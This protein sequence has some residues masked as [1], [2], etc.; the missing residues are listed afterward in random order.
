M[1]TRAASLC[2]PRGDLHDDASMPATEWTLKRNCSLSPAA[3][4][5]VYASL[6]VMSLGIATYFWLHGAT[7]VMPFAWV[8]LLVFGALLSVY[9]RHATDRERIVLVPDRLTV[10][11]LCGGRVERTEFVPQWVQVADSRDGDSLVELAGGGRVVRVGRYVPL[12]TRRAWA[13]EL[14]SALRRQGAAV[15]AQD[16]ACRPRGDGG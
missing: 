6:C 5:A 15:G 1:T 7:L 9:A 11:H 10:E 2:D 14:R 16:G 12:R 4:L 13:D 8:E 3:M